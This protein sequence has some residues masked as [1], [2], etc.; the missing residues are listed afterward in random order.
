MLQVIDKKSKQFYNFLIRT[1][2][3]FIIFLFFILIFSYSSKIIFV[4]LQNQI[5]KY[6]KKV[7]ILYITSSYEINNKLIKN[8]GKNYKF[9]LLNQLDGSLFKANAKE[10]NKYIFITDS[11]EILDAVNKFSKLKTFTKDFSI[12]LES[13]L[14]K[15][16][17]YK[18]EM[19]S[20]NRVLKISQGLGK[21]IYIGKLN[22]NAEQENEELNSIKDFI[23]SNRFIS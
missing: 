13:E 2:N 8:D 18:V 6:S 4:S 23:L 7:T 16:S 14:S 5:T 1:S 21:N 15:V 11:I 19:I 9:Q 3:R 10:Q 17:F 22:N 20:L 12:K